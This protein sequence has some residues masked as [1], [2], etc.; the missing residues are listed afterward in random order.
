MW[1]SK[2]AKEQHGLMRTLSEKRTLGIKRLKEQQQQLIRMKMEQLITDEE[3]VAQRS[4]LDG[5]LANLGRQEPDNDEK[6][7]STIEGIQSICQPL[8]K[9]GESWAGLPI[10]KQR[11]FQQ[12][13]LPAGYVFGQIGTAQKGRLFSLIS[14]VDTRESSWVP[15]EGLSWNQLAEEIIAFSA[16][17]EK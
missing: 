7:E 4:V 9:L 3:F 5:Q 14:R 16:I 13:A 11:G 10:K 6:V 1:V 8:M 12:L 15:L 2:M 17:F